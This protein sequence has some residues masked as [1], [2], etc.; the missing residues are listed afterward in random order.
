MHSEGRFYLKCDDAWS[1]ILV[2][3]KEFNQIDNVWLRRHFEM[4]RRIASLVFVAAYFGSL[5]CWNTRFSSIPNIS[6]LGRTFSFRMLIHILGF[7]VFSIKCSL[8]STHAVLDQLN[9]SAVG[10]KFSIASFWPTHH[11]T[12]ACWIYFHL[13]ISLFSKSRG[14]VSYIFVP[15]STI[16][17]E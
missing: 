14:W 12:Q 1:L 2:N 10:S 11:L 8:P 15:F 9:P 4:S 17:Y 5:S 6:E 16:F 3:A 13:R 7:I